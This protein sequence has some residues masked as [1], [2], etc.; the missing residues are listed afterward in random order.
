MVFSSISFIFFFLVLVF[1]LYFLVP[2]KAKNI[3]LLIFSLIFYAWGEPIYIILMIFS[4]VVDFTVGRFIEK[5]FH[6][7]NKKKL[8]LILSIVINLSLLGFFKYSDFLIETINSIFNISI[9]LLKLGLPIGIS[10]YTFQTMSYSVDVYR[11]EVKA[12]HNFLAFMT[13]VSMFPQLIAGPIVRYETVSQ[14]LHERTINLEKVSSGFMRF[15]RGLFKKVLIAN[16]IGFLFTTISTLDNMS[17]MTAWLGILAYT[18]QIYFDFSGYSDMAIGM[19]K[20]FGFTY[21]ENFNYPYIAKSITD[22][23]RRWHISLSSFF[24][25]YLYIPLGGSRVSKIIN[26]RNIFIVWLL[27]GLWHGAAFNFIL[28]GIYYGLILILEKFILKKYIEKLPNFFKHF[29]TLILVIIGW[30]IFAFN[31]ITMLGNYFNN[32]FNI[33]SYPLFDSMFFYYL[34]NYFVILIIATLFSTPIYNL[35]VKKVNKRYQYIIGFIIYLVLFLIT[36]ASLVS[37]TYNPFL[38]FR[39]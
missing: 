17:I 10:F 30:V 27:T 11:G 33:F 6:D 26:I 13:Y 38:Y 3:V 25:D 28:W 5:Y 16:S 9:P 20:M 32:M 2:F 12:E 34:K 1:L 23:W 19:G 14:E 8:F 29:Y 31:D 37:D 39:F 7:K 35:I 21:L 4:S 15:L 36:I 18:F 24:K 22:F